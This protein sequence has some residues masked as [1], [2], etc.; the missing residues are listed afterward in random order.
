MDAKSTAIAVR[1][2]L[3]TYRIQVVDNG[4]G[5]SSVNM[6]NVGIRF[7]T[8][9]CQSLEDLKNNT[10]RYGFR[11]EALASI[12][13]VSGKLTI[14]SRLKGTSSTYT[15][16]F[17]S[18]KIGSVFSVKER[19]EHGTTISVE[20]FLQNMHV[21]QQRI[22]QD[23]DLDDI[24][25]NMKYLAVI[26]PEVSFSLRNDVNGKMILRVNKTMSVSEAFV[27][28]FPDI[29]Y[30]SFSNLKVSKKHV[31]IDGLLYKK[32]HKNQHLQLI[33][34][35]K[36]PVVCREIQKQ[37]KK[38]YLSAC[39]TSKATGIMLNKSE[40]PVYI[41]NIRCVHSNVDFTLHP[42]KTTVMFRKIDDLL[43]CVQKI[44]RKFWE[45]EPSKCT[46]QEKVNRGPCIVKREYGVSVVGG[47][48]SMP[49]K[50]KSSGSPDNEHKKLKIGEEPSQRNLSDD[51]LNFLQGEVEIPKLKNTAPDV[52]EDYQDQATD[53]QQQGKN[54]MMNKFFKSLETY[55]NNVDRTKSETLQLEISV[56]KADQ[57]LFAA[58]KNHISIQIQTEKTVRKKQ[59]RTNAYV[60]EHD[61]LVSKCVQTSFLDDSACPKVKNINKTSKC[62]QTSIA[63]PHQYEN[64][65]FNSRF[66]TGTNYNY[67]CENENLLSVSEY[68][69]SN[70]NE[71]N[72]C[73][74]ETVFFGNEIQ[75][76]KKPQVANVF[77]E[78]VDY[79]QGCNNSHNQ[80]EKHAPNNS[81]G[82]LYSKVNFTEIDNSIDALNLNETRKSTDMNLEDIANNYDDLEK[83]D[84]GFCCSPQGKRHKNDNRFEFTMKQPVVTP[85]FAK[86]A[87]K[88]KQD[89]HLELFSN[90]DAL[91]LH[92]NRDEPFEKTVVTNC[93]SFATF[94][95][96]LQ[97]NEKF[98]AQP[99]VPNRKQFSNKQNLKKQSGKT[100]L[101]LSDITLSPIPKCQLQKCDQ[102]KE[103]NIHAKADRKRRGYLSLKKMCNQQKQ[104]T[105]NQFYGI[106]PYTNDNQASC[107]QSADLN[108]NNS[109]SLGDQINKP[110]NIKSEPNNE[111]LAMKPFSELLQS[112]HPYKSNNNRRKF[113]GF[114]LGGNEKCALQ[115]NSSMVNEQLECTISTPRINESKRIAIDSINGDSLIIVDTDDEK[116]GIKDSIQMIDVSIDS[117][118]EPGEPIIVSFDQVTTKSE[119]HIE[120]D[121]SKPK[122]EAT[123]ELEINKACVDFENTCIETDLS[124][125]MLES[126]V[127]G[128]VW[129]KHT[130]NY[131]NTYYMNERTGW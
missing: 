84:L 36:R 109:L 83:L 110:P 10:R 127:H 9:K 76:F 47:I 13:E 92:F 128:N 14:S 64:S 85:F 90:D 114:L 67:N 102:N 86:N 21:R 60:G 116:T 101:N 62:I 50:R 103:E 108:S 41:L 87:S 70:C 99:A 37:I 56:E 66:D 130:D 45:I 20:N 68:F 97:N 33:Y 106:A 89:K 65:N 129:V 18:G 96:H 88:E 122:L 46:K 131:G 93:K 32:S 7:M 29:D 54:L 100:M 126:V 55:K 98:F 1:V 24:K 59:H 63:K 57:N 44:F 23:L 12:A 115:N 77:D 3:V 71:N 52:F 35:N 31:H 125:Q 123:K 104:S 61:Q 30:E 117:L 112:G 34:V 39:N 22:K 73:Q 82:R 124:N 121:V 79:L 72:E 107:E 118:K 94:N 28:L 78:T 111:N 27:A 40:H 120:L 6:N 49:V 11:G 95:S 51:V 113:H 2:N 69:Q 8:S 81:N 53:D 25:Q 80:R 75:L 16:T 105:N 119:L 48:K 5:I 19:P 42:S 74:K 4:K 17:E 26:H 58:K 43:E 38:L 15:K 91:N